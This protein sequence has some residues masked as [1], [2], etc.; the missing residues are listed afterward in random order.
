MRTFNVK[1][2]GVSYQV[3]VEETGAVAAAP[4]ATPAPITPP[5]SV[6][7]VAA[8]APAAPVAPPAPAAPLWSFRSFQSLLISACG[9]WSG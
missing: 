4:V 5:A 6:A 8:P 7:P 1:V 3:E 9:T 2:N